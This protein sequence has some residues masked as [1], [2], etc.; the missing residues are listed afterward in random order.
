M[1]DGSMSH[2]FDGYLYEYLFPL[3]NLELNSQ[4]L[5]VVEYN[6]VG[7][8]FLKFSA[9]HEIIKHSLNQKEDKNDFIA[10]WLGRNDYIRILCFNNTLIP[11]SLI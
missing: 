3:C 8:L 6:K 7:I 4:I 5:L 11:N 1:K 10:Y 9:L 2:V